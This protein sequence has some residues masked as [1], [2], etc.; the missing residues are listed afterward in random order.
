MNGKRVVFLTFLFTVLIFSISAF[1]QTTSPVITVDSVSGVAG[2]MVDVEVTLENNVGILGAE[3]TLSYDEH[4]TLKEFSSGNAFSMLTFTPPGSSDSPCTF[5][6]DGE[7]LSEDDIK[8]GAVLKLR[9][10]ISDDALP[11]D[12]YNICIS[13]DDGQMRDY[14]LNVITP[15]FVD[16]A[17]SIVD[18]MPGDLNGDTGVDVADVI[19]LRRH[20]AGGYMQTINTYAIDVNA[21]GDIT[22]SDLILL[23]RYLAGGYD[24]EL[25]PGTNSQISSLTI[26]SD[27]VKSYSLNKLEYYLDPVNSSKTVEI[28]VDLEQINYNSNIYTSDIEDVLSDIISTDEVELYFIDNNDDEVYDELTATK[29]VS[30]IIKSVDADNNIINLKSNGKIEFDLNKTVIFENESGRKLSISDFSENNVV[31]IVSDNLSGDSYD[32]FVKVILLSDSVV[33][34]VV[35]EIYWLNDSEYVV[36]NDK[37]YICELSWPLAVGDNGTFYISKTGKI[38]DVSIEVNYAYILEAAESSSSF[39]NDTWEVKLLTAEDGVVTYGVTDDVNVEFTYYLREYFSDDAAYWEDAWLYQNST[40]KDSPDRLITYEIN[41]KNQIKNFAVADGVSRWLDMAQYNKDSQTIDGCVLEDDVII[42]N[43]T[44]SD[45]D[46]TFTT[47]INSLYDKAMYTGFIYRNEDAKNCIIVISADDGTFNSEDG[48]AIVTKVSMAK[49]A[50]GNE[51]VKVNCVRNEEENTIIFNDD[52]YTTGDIIFDELSV[53]DVFFFKSDINGTVTN[54]EVIAQTYEYVPDTATELITRISL[55]NKIPD[56]FGDYTD[57]VSGYIENDAKVVMSKG[58][59][60]TVNGTAYLISDDTNK[61]TFNNSGINTIIETEDFLAGDAY[62]FDEKTG[63]ATPVILRIVDGL[64]KDIYTS[65][66]R[67]CIVKE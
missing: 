57:F 3:L 26:W 51:V 13:C 60:I 23:R 56:T 5:I 2:A 49:D 46:D 64:V 41:S 1:A 53:G 66:D 67:V 63:E 6:W 43:I 44:S 25:L 20:L 61:Y 8:N 10:K 47:D 11:G 30:D 17:V 62:Y 58:E 15:H 34:G 32:E 16:G 33:T 40:M 36:I 37:E 38:I 19:M 65:N 45:V 21:D 59:I 12:I 35:D 9:F 7:N 18:Y 42:F 48:F 28:N 14:D 55:I 24:V 50:E 31:A 29:Y 27:D 22:I 4:L 39:S 52:S 54:Y